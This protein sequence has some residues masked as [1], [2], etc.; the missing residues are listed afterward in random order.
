MRPASAVLALSLAL[1]GPPAA[2]DA[3][4]QEVAASPNPLAALQLEEFGATLSQPLFTPSRTAPI[5]EAPVEAPPAVVE[6][7]PPQLEAPP[8]PPPF[9]LVG[10]VLGGEDEVAIFADESTGQVHRL[11]SGDEYEGWTM[12]VVDNRTVEFQS[13]DQNLTLTM[14]EEFE[15]PPAYAGYQQDWMNQQNYE[16]QSFRGER[17]ID[18]S[19]GLPIDPNTGLPTDP[20]TNQAY[21]PNTGYPID[22]AT[23]Y[24]TDPDTGQAYDPSSGYPVDPNTGQPIDPSTGQPIDP[25]TGEPIDTG[26]IP[27]R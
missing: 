13:A 7:P 15:A 5:V 25:N 11:N 20:Q 21:D 18:P 10:V 14:F 2:G 22:P 16:P 3:V 27:Q 19:T 1:A 12:D 24:P 4:A 17:T 8:A 6:A 26:S 9:K 23:G